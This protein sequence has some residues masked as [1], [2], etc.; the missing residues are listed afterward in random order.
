MARKANTTAAWRQGGTE[1]RSASLEAVD[2][3]YVVEVCSGQGPDR[4]WPSRGSS[5]SLIGQVDIHQHPCPARSQ[6]LQTH[7]IR[8]MASSYTYLLYKW[9]NHTCHAEPSIS[10]YKPNHFITKKNISSQNAT[11]LDFFRGPYCL[12]D[13]FFIH[14]FIH[15]L[16]QVATLKWV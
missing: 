11:S 12:C 9:P 6:P 8:P 2:P 16:C 4:T 7:R 1:H 13:H 15:L 3:G 10:Q 5:T 14:S